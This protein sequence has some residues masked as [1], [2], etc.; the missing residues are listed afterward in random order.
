MAIIF[1]DG[2]N[3]ML[4]YYC[5]PFFGGVFHNDNIHII[6]VDI[7]VGTYLPIDIGRYIILSVEGQKSLSII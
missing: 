2:A 7:F 1:F 6:V 4:V 3:N 5:P